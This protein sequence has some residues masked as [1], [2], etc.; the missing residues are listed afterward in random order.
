[1]I[2]YDAKYLRDKMFKILLE[3]LMFSVN[4]LMQGQG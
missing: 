2:A 3:M 1:M 4:I